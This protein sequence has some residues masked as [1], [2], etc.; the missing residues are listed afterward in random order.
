MWYVLL[1]K[2]HSIQ[3]VD[4]LQGIFGTVW[5]SILFIILFILQ[6]DTLPLRTERMRYEVEKA[7]CI[8]GVVGNSIYA[9]ACIAVMA[10]LAK[11]AAGAS[12]GDQRAGL[13][14]SAAMAAM[15]G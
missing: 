4:S 6:R 3:S 14:A 7:A 2:S 1:Q 9:T 13:G 10:V 8:V 5:N 11:L 15:A 12:N